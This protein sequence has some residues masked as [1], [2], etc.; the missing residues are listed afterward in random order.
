M[1]A[2]GDCMKKGTI[3]RTGGRAGGS[4]IPKDKNGQ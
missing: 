3:P 4:F 1:E 2:H